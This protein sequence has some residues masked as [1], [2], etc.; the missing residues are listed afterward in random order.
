MISRGP[1]WSALSSSAILWKLIWKTEENRLKCTLSKPRGM[2]YPKIFI[3]HKFLFRWGIHVVGV[4]SLIFHIWNAASWKTISYCRSNRKSWGRAMDHAQRGTGSIKNPTAKS[5]FD[6]HYALDMS[7]GST[8]HMC[9]DI[10][11]LS[12]YKAMQLKMPFKWAS[13]RRLCGSTASIV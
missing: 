4:V 8:A 6:S 11:P 9:N 5:Q 13:Q 3:W 12:H 7:I 1:F 2:W 10:L